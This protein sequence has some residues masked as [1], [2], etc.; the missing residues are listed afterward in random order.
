[1]LRGTEDTL[2]YKDIVVGQDLTGMPQ[3]TFP[4]LEEDESQA[5]H[6]VFFE[7]IWDAF[8]QATTYPSGTFGTI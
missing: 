8:V 4:L 7:Q 5:G 1:M 2:E 3:D 6:V